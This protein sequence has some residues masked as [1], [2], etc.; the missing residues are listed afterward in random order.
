MKKIIIF[1]LL[2]LIGSATFAQLGGSYT[3]N[4]SDSRYLKVINGISPWDSIYSKSEVDSITYL[5]DYMKMVRLMGS[6]VKG[7]PLAAPFPVSATNYAFVDGTAYM[8]MHYVDRSG[9]ITGAMWG[10]TA[11]ANFVADNFN[12]IGLFSVAANGTYTRIAVSANSATN[13]NAG[14]GGLQTVAFTSPVPVTAGLYAIVVLFN[15]NGAPT[16]A[17]QTFAS[18]AWGLVTQY[19]YNFSSGLI[20]AGTWAGQTD[21]P[22]SFSGTSFTRV[23]NIAQITLY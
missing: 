13:F 4:Q 16:T 12:G 22:S 1:L 19:A 14:N 3:K 15:S 17:P 21:M 11:T 2:V 7:I 23:T 6:N 20:V 10:S 18:N 8:E 5:N 9:T